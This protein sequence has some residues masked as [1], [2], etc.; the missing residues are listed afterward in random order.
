M[1]V[2]LS[3]KIKSRKAGQNKMKKPSDQIINETMP[4]LIEEVRKAAFVGGNPTD[5]AVL[6]L[7]VSKFL[8]WNPETIINVT[9]HAL[10]DSNYPADVNFFKLQKS[11]RDNCNPNR[12]KV[13]KLV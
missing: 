7:I 8:K 10:D 2:Y 9:A 3:Y 13:L 1:G 11:V 4:K 6:G 12:E 5:E